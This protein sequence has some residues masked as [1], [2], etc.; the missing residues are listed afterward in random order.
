MKRDF[1]D[2]PTLDSLPWTR[3]LP[4]DPETALVV[5]QRGQTAPNPNSTSKPLYRGPMRLFYV[6][7]SDGG[8][9]VT[10]MGGGK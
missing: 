7:W 3:K 6:R 8:V 10:I 9:D 4:S 2:Y 5:L 1:Q